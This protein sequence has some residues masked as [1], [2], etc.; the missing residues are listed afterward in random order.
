MYGKTSDK[1]F[2][3]VKYLKECLDSTLVGVLATAGGNGA[4]VTPVY[5]SYDDRFNFYFISSPG[6]RHMI[7]IEKDD[8]VALAIVSHPSVAGIHQI[9]MQ[10]SGRASEVSDKEIESVY[11]LRSKR[12]AFDQSWVPLPNGGHYVKEHGGIFMR[13]SP[14]A[15]NYFDSRF[16][17][18][19]SKKVPLDKIGGKKGL[20]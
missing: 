7:D 19:E 2:E 16:F 9:G 15:I 13:I 1:D 18:G 10:L 20:I 12:M 14:V 4:W 5:F 11:A 3:W 6:T 17:G 8:R